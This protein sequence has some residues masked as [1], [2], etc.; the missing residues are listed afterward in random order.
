MTYFGPPSGVLHSSRPWIG[1][2]SGSIAMNIQTPPR[3]TTTPIGAN[4]ANWMRRTGNDA[5]YRA[6]RV[7]AR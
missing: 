7:G 5:H 3:P 6:I 2:T 1:A 4:C